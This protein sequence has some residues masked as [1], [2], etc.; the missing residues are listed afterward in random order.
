MAEN[1]K[2]RVTMLLEMILDGTGSASFELTGPSGATAKIRYGYTKSTA[3]AA[4]GT[5]AINTRKDLTPSTA[6]DTVILQID[7]VVAC[8]ATP[9]NSFFSSPHSAAARPPSTRAAEWLPSGSRSDLNDKSEA[10][11][12]RPRLAA[13]QRSG[14]GCYVLESKA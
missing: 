8:S 3:A 9:G 13:L 11:P 10:P 5:V 12:D 14:V 6:G 2:W 1:E 4:A 7:A